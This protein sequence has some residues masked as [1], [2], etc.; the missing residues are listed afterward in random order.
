MA[1]LWLDSH[2]HTQRKKIM[3]PMLKN[4][5]ISHKNLDFGIASKRTAFIF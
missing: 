4:L 2:V 1:Q 3:K 5:K